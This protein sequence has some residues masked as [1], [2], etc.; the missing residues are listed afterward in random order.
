VLKAA[1]VDAACVGNHD[2]DF[3]IK[4]F[5]CADTMIVTFDSAVLIVTLQVE[6]GSA[7]DTQTKPVCR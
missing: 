3:G 7:L 6:Q 5:R 4:N 2:F 1:G